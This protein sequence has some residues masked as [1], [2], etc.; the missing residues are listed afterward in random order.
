MARSLPGFVGMF[1]GLGG[2]I[3]PSCDLN[4]FVAL[5]VYS[6]GNAGIVGEYRGSDSL[7]AVKRGSYL[8]LG[9]VCWRWCSLFVHTYSSL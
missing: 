6:G 2:K 8:S 1:T 7:V 4:I 3:A 9:F 5:Y